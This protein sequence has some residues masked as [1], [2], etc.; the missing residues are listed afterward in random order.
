M[1]SA[2]GICIAWQGSSIP[3]PLYNVDPSL[4][5]LLCQAWSF[6]RARKKEVPCSAVQLKPCTF[7][8]HDNFHFRRAFLVAFRAAVIKVF[9]VHFNCT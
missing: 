1:I 3:L 8:L 9:M 6:L 2:W 5:V 7:F 4:A